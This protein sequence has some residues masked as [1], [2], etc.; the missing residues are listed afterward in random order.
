MAGDTGDSFKL[1]DA[2]GRH[3]VFQPFGDG[4]RGNVRELCERPLSARPFD[5]QFDA[6]HAAEQ[7]TSGLLSSTYG[8]LHSLSAAA[9]YQPMVYKKQKRKRLAPARNPDEFEDYGQWLNAAIEGTT[10]AELG[11]YCEKSSQLIYKW[12]T[13]GSITSIPVQRLIAEWAQVDFEALRRLIVKTEEAR[14]LRKKVHM[15]V[16]KRSSPSLAKPTRSS[17][18]KGQSKGKKVAQD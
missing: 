5:H 3:A 18:S 2:L 13:S 14:A 6:V 11:R 1:Q 9:Q 4:L 16:P 7:Y 17:S 12:Q 10:P 8:L 15:D